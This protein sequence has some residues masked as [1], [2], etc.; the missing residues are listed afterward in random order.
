VYIRQYTA[1]IRYMEIPY[2]VWANPTRVRTQLHTH[3]HTQTFTHRHRNPHIYAHNYT[4]TN[5]PR[6]SHTDTE[7]HTQIHTRT[8]THTQVRLRQ[9]KRTIL[10]PHPATCRW[11]QVVDTKA[12]PF[13]QCS[14]V[15][16]SRT[17]HT[18][19]VYVILLA[20]NSPNIWSNTVYVHC[21]G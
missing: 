12:L 18:Y 20:V 2:T 19:G 16:L 6:H 11:A 21:S 3:K 4:H 15:G 8:Y 10:R 17:I 1:Y 14:C 9:Q 5:I 13:M 7:I